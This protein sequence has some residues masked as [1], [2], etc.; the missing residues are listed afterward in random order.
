MADR[1]CYAEGCSIIRRTMPMK[2]RLHHIDDYVNFLSLKDITIIDLDEVDAWMQAIDMLK[3]ERLDACKQIFL[4]GSFIICNT[5]HRL[6]LCC[7][8]R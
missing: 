6:E 7:R 5:E 1:V 4:S 2:T 3:N 8:R